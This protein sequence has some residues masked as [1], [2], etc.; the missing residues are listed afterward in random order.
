M[1]MLLSHGQAMVERWFLFNKEIMTHYRKEQ[2]LV[3]LHAVVYH[4][5][6]VGG[7][8]KA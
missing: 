4:V 1:L 5:A 2:M 3:A 6:H 7:L 8:D